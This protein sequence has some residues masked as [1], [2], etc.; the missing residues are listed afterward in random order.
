MPKKLQR[1]LP[2]PTQSAVAVA[3][4]GGG[5]KPRE[6]GGLFASKKVTP[7]VLAEFTSQLAVLLNAG[8]PITKSLRILEG[9]LPPGPMKR[10]AGSLLEDVEGGTSLSEAM[11]K[12]ELVFDALYTNMVRAG[13]AGGVQEE[14]LNRLSGFLAQSESIKSRVKGALAYPAA[15]LTVAGGVLMLVFAFVIPKFKSVFESMGQ[16]GSLHWTTETVIAI[17]EHMQVWW[18]SYLLAV[19]LL[20]ALHRLLLARVF[21][22]RSFM[23]KVALKMP[24]FGTL[25]HKSLVARFARTFG[26]LIQSGVPHLEAL[27]ILEASTRNVHM[28]SAVSRVQSSIREGAGFAVPMGESRMFDDIVVNMVDVGEQTGELDRMLAKVADRYEGEVD[29][30]VET[31]F[32]LI[33]PIILVVMAVA[34][35]FIVFALFMPL[36]TMMQ[37]LRK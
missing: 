25:V 32:K 37:T 19:V 21:G 22:Y 3:S 13:E 6:G 8:I 24:L 34:V 10:I 14:I 1:K 23:H 18:W 20:I 27:D 12:H 7:R 36:L 2:A 4:A 16:K 35:G 17:G 9:Q 5:A 28:K 26:T 33:E 11:Q 31:T 15:I 30:T 29:R